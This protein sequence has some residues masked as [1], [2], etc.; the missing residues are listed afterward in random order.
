MAK[1]EEGAG[2]DREG[3]GVME[4]V[5]T[6]ELEGSSDFWSEEAQTVNLREYPE[7]DFIKVSDRFQCAEDI[8]AQ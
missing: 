6:G 5:V 3:T 4:G 2:E 7:K 8:I 1:S